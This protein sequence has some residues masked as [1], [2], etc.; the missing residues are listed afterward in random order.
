VVGGGLTLGGGVG[1]GGAIALTR[2]VVTPLAG[3]YSN[4]CGQ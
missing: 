4:A 2:T 1:G 3:R